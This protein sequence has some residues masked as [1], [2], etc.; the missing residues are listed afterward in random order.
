MDHPLRT[1]L[2]ALALAVGLLGSPLP[3][4]PRRLP[5][6]PVNLNTASV[7]ELLQLPRVGPRTAERIVAWR[8][9]HGRFRRPEDLM[10]VKGIGEKAFQRM[11]A[12]VTAD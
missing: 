8:E 5:E 9:E 3:A 6:R 2:A 1:R 4:A 10:N 7:T 12:H 11:K